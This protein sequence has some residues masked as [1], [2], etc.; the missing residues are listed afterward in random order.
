MHG[1]LDRSLGHAAEALTTNALSARSDSVDN[2][3][4]GIFHNEHILVAKSDIAKVHE[5]VEEVIRSETFHN[6]AVQNL[7][8]NGKE[9]SALL[10]A[11]ILIVQLGTAIEFDQSFAKRVLRLLHGVI[12]DVTLVTINSQ[13]NDI[14]NIFHL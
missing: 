4:I 10:A 1:G 3:Q 5:L 13:L 12:L 9:L 8:N 11:Q 6:G 7:L 14:L 2:E